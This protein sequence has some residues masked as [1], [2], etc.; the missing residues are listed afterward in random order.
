MRAI[1]F[2]TNQ[3]RDLRK[4]FISDSLDFF[5]IFDGRKVAIFC[6]VINNILCSLGTDAFKSRKGFQIGRIDIDLFALKGRIAFL[7]HRLARI[8]FTASG[9]SWLYRSH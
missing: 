4:D 8:C 1:L 2:H 6:A 9:D 7:S 5:Q 3:R